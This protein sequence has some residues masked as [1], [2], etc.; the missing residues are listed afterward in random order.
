VEAVADTGAPNDKM[1][2][3]AYGRW[4]EA[5]TDIAALRAKQGELYGWWLEVE[6]EVAGAMEGLGVRRISYENKLYTLD[7]GASPWTTVLASEDCLTLTEED[8]PGQADY[9]GGGFSYMEEIDVT[10]VESRERYIKRLLKAAG[11]ANPPEVI[12]VEAVRADLVRGATQDAAADK[13]RDR[14]A[15]RA[16]RNRRRG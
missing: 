5:K 11:A 16:A 10:S 12:D 1:L 13:A 8:Q 15:D 3:E 6:A 9:S 14:R 7:G 2:G 4:L